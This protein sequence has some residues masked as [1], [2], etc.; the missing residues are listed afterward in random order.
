MP[1]VGAF[2]G[3][4]I[5]FK[6]GCILAGIQLL[7]VVGGSSKESCD[8]GTASTGPDF[9]SEVSSEA[10]SPSGFMLSPIELMLLDRDWGGVEGGDTREVMILREF[11]M[12]GN[13]DDYEEQR[14]MGRQRRRLGVRMCVRMQTETETR[15][16]EMKSLGGQEW[17]IKTG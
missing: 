5:P 6:Q 15:E 10:S 3:R 9:S 7:L 4:D 17:L 14:S 1:P 16:R 11:M 8:G 2:V 13:D 12:N